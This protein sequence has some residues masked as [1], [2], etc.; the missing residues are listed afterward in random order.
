MNEHNHETADDE[1]SLIEIIDFFRETWIKIVVSGIIG[2]AL[3]VGYSLIAPSKFQTV[4]S[5][6]VRKVA[7]DD[8]ETP[9]VLLENLK[10][11]TY[12]TQSTLTACNVTEEEEPGVALAKKLNPKLNKNAPAITITYK[13]LDQLDDILNKIG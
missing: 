2:G 7:G 11:P 10:M 9:N 8:V 4:A 13:D 12:Y 3:G 6:Q 1:L 5:I